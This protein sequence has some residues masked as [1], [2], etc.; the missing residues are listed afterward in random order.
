[1]PLT[2][3][4]LENEVA[5]LCGLTLGEAGL[6]FRAMDGGD[7]IT[8]VIRIGLR[9]G[10][11]YVGIATADPLEVAD[12]DL[13]NLSTKAK[14]AVLAWGELFGLQIALAQWH[15]AVRRRGA[16]ALEREPMLGGWLMEEK[17]ATR[18]RVAELKAMVAG[19]YVEPSNPIEVSGGGPGFPGCVPVPVDP[20]WGP[21]DPYGPWDGGGW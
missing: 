14:E 17:R 21:C 9:K 4:G 8:P 13:A 1:M 15:R 18:E 3:A 6:L 11:S 7:P 2:V 16:E 12:S 10:L 20:L 5:S 19:P